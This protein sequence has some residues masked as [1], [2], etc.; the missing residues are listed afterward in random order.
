MLCHAPSRRPQNTQEQEKLVPLSAS[1]LNLGVDADVGLTLGNS[2]TAG[3]AVS[4]SNG[5][6][7]D[8]QISEANG[9]IKL[10]RLKLKNADDE[11]SWL[12]SRVTDLETTVSTMR[13]AMAGS[14][15]DGAGDHEFKGWRQVVSVKYPW[16]RDVKRED[17]KRHTFQTDKRPPFVLE[18]MKKGQGNFFNA[19]KQ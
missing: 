8:E 13:V 10:L 19:V 18:D 9:E 11:S 6:S 15:E 2:V 1:E 4:R 17:P 16:M 14:L 3:G 5:S 12:R 7:N